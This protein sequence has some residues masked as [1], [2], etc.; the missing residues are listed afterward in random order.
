MEAANE[1]AGEG[2]SFGLNIK[3]PNEQAANPF[4]RDS[5][6]LLE[7]KYF[8][9][10]KLVFIKESHATVLLPGGFGTLDEGF[11][12]ITLF[13]TG[14]CM[15]RPIVL[16]DHKDDDYWDKWLHFLDSIL[17]KNGY[18]SIED[19]HLI[20][21]ARNAEEAVSHIKS[22]Y[23]VFHSLRYVREK[24]ILRLNSALSAECLANLNN[25]FQDILHKGKIESTDPLKEELKNKE[26][27]KLPRISLFFDKKSFGRL[28]LL[29]TRIN[30]S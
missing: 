26:Y 20:K 9:T 21:R 16:L 19:G 30:Q 12:N 25:E 15:P 5:P 4:I 22:F 10:R 23:R 3:L 28:N 6:N 2:K 14:K 1:G 27:L 7:F 24:T 11:E 8:F 29:I 18:C 17:I 13:Q